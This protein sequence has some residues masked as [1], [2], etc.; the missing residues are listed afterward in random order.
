MS[1]STV[2]VTD[3]AVSWLS[4]PFNTMVVTELSESSWNG[5][6]MDVV[7][8]NP[9]AGRVAVV[10]VKTSRGDFLAGKKK[11]SMYMKFCHKFYVAAPRGM[12]D[13]DE[14]PDGVGLLECGATGRLRIKKYAGLRTMEAHRYTQ[15]LGRVIQKLCVEGSRVSTEAAWREQNKE[16]AFRRWL[17]DHERFLST[18]PY[19][20]QMERVFA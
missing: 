14:L 10:E 7:A 5:K 4:K 11:F 18:R 3:A 16:W 19:A 1:I 20:R 15:I 2:L 9:N 17:R 13:P 8:V 6:R 12:I